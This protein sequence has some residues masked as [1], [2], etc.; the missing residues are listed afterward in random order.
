MSFMGR[1]TRTAIH[2]SRH[3]SID[4]RKQIEL[5]SEDV[6]KRVKLKERTEGKKLQFEE[7]EEEWIQDM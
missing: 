2:N 3:R 1:A 4:W 6:E 5:R 7:G